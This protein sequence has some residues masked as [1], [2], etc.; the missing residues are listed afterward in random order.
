[1]KRIFIFLK[2]PYIQTTY[3]QEPSVCALLS[4]L[5]QQDMTYHKSLHQSF[6]DI[7]V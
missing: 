1:M 3:T 6:Q 2:T 4:W 7:M 5:T